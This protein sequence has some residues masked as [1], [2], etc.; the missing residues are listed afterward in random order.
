[1]PAHPGTRASD[2]LVQGVMTPSRKIGPS[3]PQNKQIEP[4]RIAAMFAR[5]PWHTCTARAMCNYSAAHSISTLYGPA[6][7]GG[8]SWLSSLWTPRSKAPNDSR[9]NM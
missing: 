7:L 8:F 9:E 4:A 5:A 6:C 3:A 1:M 2:G